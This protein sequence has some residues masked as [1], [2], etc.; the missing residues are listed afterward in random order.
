MSSAS[1]AAAAADPGA[2][3]AAESLLLTPSEDGAPFSVLQHSFALSAVS[4]LCFC[5]VIVLILLYTMC[6]RDAAFAHKEPQRKRKKTPDNY[7]LSSMFD[8]E[9]E[10]SFVGLNVPLLRDNSSL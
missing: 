8:W 1:T 10:N 7:E 4:S 5:A 3:A 2:A 6:R 9:Y